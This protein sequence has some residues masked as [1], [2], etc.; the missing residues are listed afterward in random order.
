VFV[1]SDRLTDHFS[2]QMAYIFTLYNEFNKKLLS[3]TSCIAKMLFI[4]SWI[5]V[6]KDVK[7]GTAA[8]K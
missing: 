4:N 2:V 7:Q 8:M 6:K 3:Q 5:K 1:Q